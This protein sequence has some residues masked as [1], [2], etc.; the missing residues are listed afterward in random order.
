MFFDLKFVPEPRWS[1][2]AVRRVGDGL[3]CGRIM[4]GL[5]S[6]RFRIVNGVLLSLLV[7]CKYFFVGLPS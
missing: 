5:W 7:L 1:S 4:V 3:V 6:D 2:S